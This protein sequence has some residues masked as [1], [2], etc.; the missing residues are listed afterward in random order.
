MP[1]LADDQ[2][3]AGESMTSPG[4]VSTEI[5]SDG[6]LKASMSLSETI[7]DMRR[8]IFVSEPRGIFEREVI[9]LRFRREV[10]LQLEKES[11]CRW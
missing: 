6:P 10:I 1:C 4:L 8:G 11:V 3:I 5:G 2:S 7:E 9:G